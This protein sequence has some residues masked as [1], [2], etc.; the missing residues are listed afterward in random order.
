LD[1]KWKNFKKKKIYF[2]T[3]F[4]ISIGIL[5]WINAD[6]IRAIDMN[7]DPQMAI[8]D[9]YIQT[10]DFRNLYISKVDQVIND[11][12]YISSKVVQYSIEF[13][14]GQKRSNSNIVSNID[15]TYLIYENNELRS[16]I[17]R[18]SW[19]IIS[20]LE[21][22]NI[23]RLNFT[24]SQD[25]MNEL[26]SEWDLRR[27]PIV[28]FYILFLI[29][30]SL[31]IMTLVLLII[32]VEKTRM[33]ILNTPYTELD[34]LILLVS[35]GSLIG[36][37]SL[38]VSIPSF[39]ESHTF[40]KGIYAFII[41]IVTTTFLGYSF[42]AIIKKIKGKRLIKSTL[43]YII[44][45]KLVNALKELFLQELKVNIETTTLFY[46]D[47]RNYVVISFILVVLTFIFL[48]IPPVPF[49]TIVS[50]L[51][52]SYRFLKTSKQKLKVLETKFMESGN[53]QYKAHNL[54][55]DLITNVSHDIRTPL[56]SIITY[57]DLLSMEELNENSQKYIQVLKEKANRLKQI[58]SDIFELAK[59]TSDN[60]EISLEKI[61]FKVLVEQSL[62][63]M[64]DKFE[65]SSLKLKKEFPQNP[66]FINTDGNKMYRVFQ[67][68]FENVLKYSLD[69]SRVHLQMNISSGVVYLS[70]KNIS[71]NEIDF[72]PNE[73]I[74]R[75]SRSADD[76]ENDGIGL[77]LSIA[78]SLTK[79]CNGFFDV[80]IDGDM[81]K[82]TIGFRIANEV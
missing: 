8:F 77:G 18:N 30:V 22:Y 1:T 13:E 26:E 43:I 16:D 29:K 67:N 23:T 32:L 17:L 14:N 2:I 41:G 3:L 55:V 42:I 5:S 15:S 12:N 65:K 11:E 4:I 9:D 73:I 33:G 20:Y 31:F 61:D 52:I 51:Y 35:I 36:F 48:Y 25:Y 39:L 62:V 81:F 27:E 63:E 57:I 66:V 6:L 72:S 78:Q 37:D 59:S 47:L 50:E 40:V 10:G 19:N 28:D 34:L 44:A 60:V 56:T 79:A 75:Y 21:Q 24:F 38:I 7:F 49:F 69:N 68:I 74:K 80:D 54:K 46:K 76:N 70:V 58:I 64:E 45:S 82:V 71:K 53:E